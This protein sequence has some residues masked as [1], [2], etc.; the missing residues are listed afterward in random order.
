ML[1]AFDALQRLNTH[2]HTHMARSP[3]SSG[4]AK[5]LAPETAHFMRILHC[6]GLLLGL[7]NSFHTFRLPLY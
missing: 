7:A 4:L 6:P 5:R 3:L 1:T 2:I